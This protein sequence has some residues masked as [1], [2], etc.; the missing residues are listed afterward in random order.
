[1]LY[2]AGI[3]VWTIPSVYS[4]VTVFITRVSSREIGWSAVTSGIVC[5]LIESSRSISRSIKFYAGHREFRSNLVLTRLP[6]STRKF[7]PVFDGE[8]LTPLVSSAAKELPR[9]R[10]GEKKCSLPVLGALRPRKDLWPGFRS[11]WRARI[12]RGEFFIVI[13]SAGIVVVFSVGKIVTSRRRA[14]L[15]FR[16]SLPVRFVSKR[17]INGSGEDRVQKRGETEGL[18]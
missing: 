13:I 3:S 7:S 11:S 15:S 6:A 9:Q 18:R 16:R 14:A 4:Y 10:G 17:F 5:P 8:S 12:A 1:M 2:L